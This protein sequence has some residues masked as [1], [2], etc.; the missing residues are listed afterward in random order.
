MYIFSS[1]SPTLLYLA[2]STAILIATTDQKLGNYNVAQGILFDTHQ[3]LIAHQI[4]IPS[5][6]RRN[7]LLLHSYILAKVYLFIII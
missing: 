4:S 5:E 2:A 6:L 7:L 3:D 1:S